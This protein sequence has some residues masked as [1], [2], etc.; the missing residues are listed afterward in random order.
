M[1][2]VKTLVLSSKSDDLA[3]AAQIWSDGG[4]VA[5]P[6]ETVYGLGTD[7][8]NDHA[9][10]QIYA[11]KGRPSFNP[12]IVHV[13][14]V[15]TA[16][17]YVDFSA[18]AELLASEFWPGALT[19]VLPLRQD[20][21]I[22]PLV[23]AGLTTLAIRVPNGDVAQSVLREFNGPIAAPSANPSGRVSPT[24]A[25]HVIAGL[26]GRIDAVIDGGQCG[27][28]VESTIVGC[29]REPALLRL[30]GVPAEAIEA[31]LGRPLTAAGE[32][33]VA[34]GQLASHYAPEG[35]MRL[36]VTDAQAD[37][38]LLG[39]G[40]VEGAALSLSVTG[41]LVEAA[42]NLFDCLHQLNALGATKIAVSPVPDVGLG[43]AINDRLARAAAPRD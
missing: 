34:P 11:A 10:A 43:R 2:T 20:A 24:S 35:T 42:A 23:T 29:V 33:I 30:G 16:R 6:T 40:P 27:V 21:G 1:N 37:E 9:V 15:E 28:G 36:N 26:S 8:R 19:L 13:P 38:T 22:S 4:L 32:E 41:D 39:F 17:R 14:D 12:L 7:A 5:F 25:A 18:E 31:A 3:R